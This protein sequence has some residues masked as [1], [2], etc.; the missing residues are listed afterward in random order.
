[1]ITSQNAYAVLGG[2]TGALVCNPEEGL[3]SAGTRTDGRWCQVY[4]R[5][6]TTAQHL[7]R[8]KYNH[9]QAMPQ[10]SSRWVL[11]LRAR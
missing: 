6:V 11:G 10:T 1:M 7:A 8:Y 9:D 4:M 3:T 5:T 2:V